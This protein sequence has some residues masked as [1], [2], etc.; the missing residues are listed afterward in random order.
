MYNWFEVKVKYEKITEN[1]FQKKVIEPYLVDALSHAE[2][3]ARA[4]EELKPYIAGEFEI[5]SVRRTRINEMFLNEHGDRFYKVKV[6]FIVLDE[7]SGA[8]KRQSVQM[9]SQAN[10]IRKA[11]DLVDENMKKKMIDYVVTSVTETAIMDIF[12]WDGTSK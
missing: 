7:K 11:I 12:L 6:A 9:Y 3:E 4:V 10:D 2:A 8:E 5:E 1:G